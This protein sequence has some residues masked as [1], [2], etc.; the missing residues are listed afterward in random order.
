MKT[1]IKTID[2]QAKE[3]FDKMNGNSYFAGKVTVDFGL[4]TEKSFVMPFQ[5]GYGEQY[6]QEARNTLKENNV[7]NM[8]NEPLWTLRDQKVIIRQS[9]QRNCLKRELKEFQL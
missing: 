2:I 5:Y 7:I 1:S 3:W 6:I 9:I 4:P 8:N